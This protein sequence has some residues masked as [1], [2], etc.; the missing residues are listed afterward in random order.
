MKV[1]AICGSPRKEGSTAK[2]V[3]KFADAA[4]TSGAEVQSFQLNELKFSGCQ[5]CVL[6][7]KQKMDH[8]RL[9]D[10][11]A[12]VLKA[13][14]AADVLV[15]GSP[16]YM[17]DVTA[18]AKAFIDRTF[19]FFKPDFKTNPNP[20]RLENSKTLVL[21]L[22]QGAPVEQAFKDVADRYSAVLSRSCGCK[23]VHVVRGLNLPPVGDAGAAL[24][25]ALT[26]IDEVARTV[27]K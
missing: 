22:T 11:L 15:V 12:P 10:D 5:S 7:C 16:V 26:R 25:P 27:L 14:A 17:S 8:C 9:E 24:E 6:A 13:V 23:E 3:N 18:Q 1:V 19:S 21:V 2:L 4:K 20:S